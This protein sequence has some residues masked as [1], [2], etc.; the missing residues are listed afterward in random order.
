MDTH[1][2]DGIQSDIAPYPH[3]RLPF[4]RVEQSTCLDGTFNRWNTTP[5]QA[6]GRLWISAEPL[7]NFQAR[8]CG[9]RCRLDFLIHLRPGAPGHSLMQSHKG[10]SRR[11]QALRGG[12]G[13]R[14]E[15][16]VVRNVP[17]FDHGRGARATV[18][19]LVNRQ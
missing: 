9:S 18:L 19:P 12:G 2:G 3:P 16:S 6:Q 7:A 17:H 14:R 1:V 8:P 10:G 13:W 11:R 5:F 4:Y 15:L